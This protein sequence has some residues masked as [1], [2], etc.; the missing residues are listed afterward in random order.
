MIS[1]TEL[2]Q[3]QFQG[4]TLPDPY[5]TVLGEIPVNASGVIWGPKGSGKSTFAVDLAFVLA[6]LLGKGLYASSEEGAGPSM[7]GKIKRLKAEHP[8]LFVDDFNGFDELKAAVKFAD[9]KFIILDSA[10]M[11]RVKVSELEAFHNW[12]KE[13]PVMFW[14]VLH[15][16]KDGAYKGNSML[17]HLPDI[18]LK[19]AEGFVQSEKN[20][21][22]ECPREMEVQF[23]RKQRK[24]PPKRR[25]QKGD[26]VKWE[27]RSRI[28]SSIETKHKGEVSY[29]VDDNTVLVIRDMPGHA[30]GYKMNVDENLLEPIE[31]GRSNPKIAIEK[32]EAAGEVYHGNR[33]DQHWMMDSIDV[34]FT[35]EPWHY[36]TDEA[37]KEFNLKGIEFGN[38]MSEKDSTEYLAWTM[39]AFHNLSELLGIKHSE[40]GLRG[41]LGMAFG[42]RGRGLAAAHYEPQKSPVINLTKEHGKGSLAH[43]YGHALDNVLSAELKRWLTGGRSI[44]KTVDEDLLQQPGLVGKTEEILKTLLIRKD[45]QYTA[46]CER[47]HA[48]EGDYWKRRNEIFARTFEA[49]VKFRC[50]QQNI[51]HDYLTKSSYSGQMYPGTKLLKKVDPLLEEWIAEVFAVLY[52]TPGQSKTKESKAPQKADSG[53][54]VTVDFKADGSISESGEYAIMEADQL[55]ASHNPDCSKNSDH[56]ISKGQPRNRASESL[57][58]QPKFIAKNLKPESIT[59]GNLAFNGAPTVLPDGQVIQGNGRTLAMKIAYNEHPGK[60]KEYRQY[61]IDNASQYGLK[62]EEVKGYD[63]PVLVR[64]LD[65]SDERAVELGNVVDTSQAKMNRIDQAKAFVRNLPATKKQI[66]GNL[67]NQSPGETLGEVLDST[68]P[69][70]LDQ[71]KDL[72]RDGLIDNDGLT[73]EGKEFLKSV[74][75]GLVFDSDENENALQY[76]MRLPHT[77]R[78]GLERSYGNVIPFIGTKSDIT[79]Q[80]QK[81]V[82]ITVKVKQ[83]DGIDTVEQFMKEADMFS[84]SNKGKYSKQE[85]ALAELFLNATTQKEIRNAF[86]LYKDKIQGR[87]DMFDPVEKVGPK[88]AFKDAFITRENP[89]TLSESEVNKVIAEFNEWVDQI[90]ETPRMITLKVWLQKNHPELA[91]YHTE[92]WDQYLRSNPNDDT[93]I[94]L[95]TV[96]EVTIDP[97]DG[98][99]KDT[100]RGDFQM[101]S[102]P[103]KTSLYIVPDA[104]VT[105]ADKSVNDDEADAHFEEFHHY[106]A[107]DNDLMIDWPDNE[108]PVR[109]G[110]AKTIKYGSDK[111]IQEGDKK[112]KLNWYVHDFDKNKRPVSV[113]DQIMKI[114]R[115]E[116]DGRG[117]LN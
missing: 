98:I 102:S 89:I 68:G 115:I 108:Q 92:I 58:A 24:N 69:R 2:A 59:Q 105:A 3:K 60:A 114:D 6:G 77:V 47:V 67:I 32:K 90:D 1:T 16:T 112:G 8:N 14:Y 26:R 19:V 117:I 20:R 22:E 57:C 7:Q 95:G 21:F 83:S 71:F 99:Q 46:F 39:Q 4:I 82:D 106:S 44:R 38:W 54:S 81:A 5:G 97:D 42:A 41:D 51:P 43:E 107:D 93:L 116:W 109:I 62:A 15:A 23:T 27:K 91:S 33:A 29:Y 74:F 86:R 85:Q 25:F 94:Y 88:K 75:A 80:I 31:D 37:L 61:L 40:I 35:P 13:Q 111:I 65:V 9:I 113:I 11:S 78:A 18:E 104:L 10:T 101:F 34:P 53:K 96:E 50:D 66:I 56:R 49:W 48:V 12:C 45:G 100:L 64:K 73:A 70:I 87:E 72:D 55:I 79:D 63:K 28:A 36:N 52:D 103:D 76:F 17:V 84:G 110:T 30:A